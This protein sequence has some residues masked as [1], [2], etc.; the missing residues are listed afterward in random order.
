RTEAAGVLHAVE[1][2]PGVARAFIDRAGQVPQLQVTVDRERAAR[3][4][5]NI[6][7]V[8]DT[9]ETALGGKAATEIWEG[10]R[11]FDV[12]VRL[13]P[14]QRA[15]VDTVSE[16]RVD[17]SEG[18]QVRLSDVASVAVR[19]GAMNIARESGARVMAIGVFIRGRDMGSVVADMQKKVT[20][21]VTFGQGA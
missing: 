12:V 4:G 5:L 20:A 2:V 18:A 7:D 19:D 15:D 21:D 8:Q 6:A 14:E 9:I 17:T 16:I 11:K 3:Y 1:S 10:E 13:P